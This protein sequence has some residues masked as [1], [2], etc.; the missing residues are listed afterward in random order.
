MKPV[1]WGIMPVSGIFMGRVQSPLRRSKL[2]TLG[3]IASRSVE[4]ARSAANAAGIPRAYGSYEELLSDKDV[5]A[6]YISLPNNLHAEWVIKAIDAGKHVLCE[7]PFALN[8]AQAEECLNHAQ[9]KG[10][11]AMESF[12]YRFHPQWQHACEL[13]RL[14]E[15]GEIR[16][17]SIS[18]FYSNRDP[19]NIRNN[20]ALG[21]GALMDIGCY[22]VSCARLLLNKE[23]KRVV[24]AAIR[25]EQFGTDSQFSGI[26]DFETSK[27]TFTVGTQAHLFQRVL[28][29]GTSGC[30]EFPIPFNPPPDI[31]SHLIV[32]GE[33]GVRNIE[34]APA[35]QY[36]LVFEAFSKAIRHEEDSPNDPRDTINNMKVIDAL[37]RSETSHAWE[38]V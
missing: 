30:V 6:V 7:K 15:I 1:I 4:R 36:G 23:P 31:S 24:A 22:A 11:L 28:V 33:L 14:G 29:G 19:N 3:C 12:M 38:I 17:V 25:D 34:F 21:G 2:V 27:C 10:V 16:S 18:F 13:V 35:N 26:L 32:T 9:K 20:L 5:E 8:A 37:F